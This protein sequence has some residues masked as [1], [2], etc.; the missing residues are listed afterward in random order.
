MANDRLRSA[1][2]RSGRGA[3]EVAEVL[4]VDPKTVERWLGGRSPHPR[5]RQAVAQLLGH[6]EAYLWP[7]TAAVERVASASRSELVTLYPHRS[8]VPSELWLELLSRAS[9][10]VDVL[11]Y[12]A[13]FLP[14]LDPSLVNDLAG[15][16]AEGARVRVALGEA[17]GAAVR[18]RGDE[19][20]IGHGMAARVT[21][22]LAH[23]EP[24]VG[25]PGVEVHV[26]GTT[27]YNSIFRFD[28]EL[29]VNT[30]LYGAKAYQNP[31]LHLRRVEGGSLFTDYVN[32]FER[33]WAQSKAYSR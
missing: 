13:L 26:H 18:L 15:R 9:R 27:L 7:D 16:A 17:D 10:N 22:T 23:L 4:R 5:H 3:T 31:V 19:E 29:L 20:G 24:L 33:V 14:E 32:S 8:A 25:E 28:D 30:H 11:A 21:M 12:A 2:R 1:L 6:E